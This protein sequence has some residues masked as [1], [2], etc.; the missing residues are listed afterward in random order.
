MDDSQDNKSI[1]AGMSEGLESSEDS[2]SVTGKE[3][4]S[5]ESVK[6]PVKESASFEDMMQ[7]VQTLVR[8]MSDDQCPLDDIVLKVERG[9]RLI[10]SMR[11]RLTDT[12]QRLE[13]LQKEF[14][15]SSP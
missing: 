15:E 11:T 7:E 4:E 1:R 12:R 8:S 5:V 2:L 6:E 3:S 9:F 13:G 14:E 10:H